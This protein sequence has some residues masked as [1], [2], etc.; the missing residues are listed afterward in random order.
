MKLPRGYRGWLRMAERRGWTVP[1]NEVFSQQIW[2]NFWKNMYE[3][4]SK[5]TEGR[6]IPP[7]RSGGGQRV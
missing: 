7:H 5:Q 1:A 6:P 4:E 2:I 3:H